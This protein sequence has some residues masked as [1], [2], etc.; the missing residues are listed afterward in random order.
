MHS[1][2]PWKTARSHSPAYFRDIKDAQGELIAQV[3]DLENGQPEVL[4]NARLI[5][6]APDMLEALLVALPFV[7]DLEHDECYKA[8]A[9]L[10]AVAQ[11]RAAIDK[12]TQ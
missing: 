2:T 8:G 6:A 4:E 5:C 3:C 11:I 9:V 1:V 12:A 10:K 7:E